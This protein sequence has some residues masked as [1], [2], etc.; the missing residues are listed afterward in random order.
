MEKVRVW[1]CIQK[2][3]G[4]G[5][6]PDRP[7]G[8]GSD[9][10]PPKGEIPLSEAVAASENVMAMGAC[11]S[12][13][14][15]VSRKERSLQSLVISYS[16]KWKKTVSVKFGVR[17]VHT[18]GMSEA[19]VITCWG[20]N[21]Y[22]QSDCR[23]SFTIHV[24]RA[25]VRNRCRVGPARSSMSGTPAMSGQNRPVRD[26]RAYAMY[27]V[28]GDRVV[29]RRVP[30]QRDRAV[31]VYHCRQVPRRGWR[32]LGFLGFFRIV[33]AGRVGVLPCRPA[34]GRDPA[35]PGRPR[36]TSAGWTAIFRLRCR[37]PRLRRSSGL[38]AARAIRRR[39]R[40]ARCLS[41]T[42]PYARPPARLGSPSRRS[43]PGR[44]RRSPRVR[45]RCPR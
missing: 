15:S 37:S 12:S 10:G 28:A 14:R 32:F 30:A 11:S 5:T 44:G 6:A 16:L 2:T 1:A 17:V 23:S 19:G 27:L 20:A 36:S 42:D 40:S 9:K 34:V 45:S 18:C 39:R 13:S 7:S 22:G 29:V 35:V 4:A 41:P 38:R 31:P 26:L 25:D 8:V 33:P 24:D 43:P 21:G 3:Q